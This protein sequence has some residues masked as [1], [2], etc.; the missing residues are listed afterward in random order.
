MKLFKL[1]I[2]SVKNK[3]KIKNCVPSFYNDGIVFF[4]ITAVDGSFGLSEPSPYL[5]NP[6]FIVK[7]IEQFYIKYIKDKSIADLNFLNL[8]KNVKNN[9]LEYNL[10][11]SFEQSIYDLK[12]KIAKKNISFFL[13]KNSHK[14][15]IKLYASGGMLFENESYDR[16]IDEAIRYK[17]LGYMGWKFRPK[18]PVANLSHQQRIKNPPDFDMTKLLFFCEKIRKKVGDSFNLM[19][20]CGCR[21]KNIQKSTKL[22]DALNELNFLFVEEPFKRKLSNYLKFD[23]K[24][25]T[26]IIAGGENF[27][28][29]KSFLEFS[30]LN[31]VK[32]IQPD[33]NLLTFWDLSQII[34]LKKNISIHNWCNKINFSMNLNFALSVNNDDI[35]LEH[36][37]I[38]SPYN[39]LFEESYR[40]KNGHAYLKKGIFG[41]GRL[42]KNY[43]NFFLSI[44]EKEI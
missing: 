40:I 34:K 25:K 20:D 42:N 30:K 13:N 18:V 19:L 5:G 26:K 31:S 35:I 38:K 9:T 15:K 27:N 22:F 29:Y 33:T 7:K 14:K 43:K 39:D 4:K 11:P 8:R 1:N 23:K 2:F 10:V 17:D 37:I 44:Y 6:D 24:Y 32:Y 16:L 12:S 3:K 21:I 28:G 36:N 41:L